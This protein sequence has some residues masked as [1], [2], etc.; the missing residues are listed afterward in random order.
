[1][2]IKR[3]IGIIL[4]VLLFLSGCES[5]NP[6][7]NG[8]T[9][10]TSNLET[11]P[12]DEEKDDA[13][14]IINDKKFFLFDHA[15][16]P[17]G[18]VTDFQIDGPIDYYDF[19]RPYDSYYY[20]KNGNLWLHGIHTTVG[21]K[22]DYGEF[23]QRDDKG[24]IITFEGEY[25]RDNIYYVYDEDNN[26]IQE[27]G[28]NDIGLP[29]SVT[30]YEDYDEHGNY[31][32][33]KSIS[34]TLSSSLMKNNSS[35]YDLSGIDDYPDYQATYTYNY[36]YDDEGRVISKEQLSYEYYGERVVKRCTYEYDEHGNLI[37]EKISGDTYIR[38]YH[39][40]GKIA[41]LTKYSNQEVDE[42]ITYDLQGNP[43]KKVESSGK[44]TNYAN[45]Y[46]AYGNLVRQI[47]SDETGKGLYCDVWSYVEEQEYFDNYAYYQPHA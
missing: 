11:N 31:R 42:Q 47:T 9:N 41:S 36:E 30:I 45:E 33:S 46:D 23:W 14:E 24:N 18:F 6:A 39:S 37:Y 27:W 4:V 15:T 12:P 8:N 20:D 19:A 40:N 34:N 13:P 29:V 17:Y 21:D 7:Q 1:M 32:R 10:A 28:H 3:Y 44:V 26:L 5:T 38:E 43:V 16:I 35:W 25:L 22:A 2:N